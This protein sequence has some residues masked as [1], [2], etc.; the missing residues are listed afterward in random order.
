MQ[1]VAAYLADGFCAAIK[2]KSN[3]TVLIKFLK[4]KTVAIGKGLTTRYLAYERRFFNYDQ[5]VRFT[6]NTDYKIPTEKVEALK[7][8]EKF[9]DLVMTFSHWS[10]KVSLIF[11]E[12][13][14]NGVKKKFNMY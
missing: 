2:K 10:Y 5:F 4:P 8:P 1:T 12:D 3:E 13:F 14:K 11:K 7:I 9:V 6:N